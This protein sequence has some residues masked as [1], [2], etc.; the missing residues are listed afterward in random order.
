ML[1]SSLR[2]LWPNPEAVLD[3]LGITP[4]LRAENLPLAGFLALAR[5]YRESS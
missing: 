4:T 5:S 1:R 2:P 3:S